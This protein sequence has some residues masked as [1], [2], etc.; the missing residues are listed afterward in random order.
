PSTTLIR[1]AGA[2]VAL[3]AVALLVRLDGP[4]QGARTLA[5]VA[6]AGALTGLATVPSSPVSLDDPTPPAAAPEDGGTVADPGRDT[7]VLDQPGSPGDPPTLEVPA[8]ARP[9]IEG[10]SVVAEHPDGTR[11]VLGPATQGTTV[12]TPDGVVVVV[13][14]GVLLEVPDPVPGEAAVPD[15]VDDRIEA[16][17]ALLLGAFA[18]LAFSPPVVRFARSAVD[19]AEVVDASPAEARRPRRVEDGLADVLRAMLADP[20]P[21]T[22]VIGAYARLLVAL[23]EAG[24]PRRPHEGPHEHLWRALG[25]LGV[26]RGPVHRLAE[27]FVRARF[28]P[29]PVTDDHRR[30][31]IAALADAIADLRLEAGAVRDGDV[32]AL[33]SE[34]SS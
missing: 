11:S 31:A 29:H 12:R 8:G 23:D 16:L 18:L 28:T 3:G 10:G 24:M 2:L 21:R 13:G 1:G 6:V 19:P 33:V 4:A 17:L 26:R 5:L 22:A 25:P 34:T 7:V 14:D 30:V 15:P 9:V 27:L 32:R 20:D